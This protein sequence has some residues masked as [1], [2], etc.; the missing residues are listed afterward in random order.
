[1]K[2]LLSAIIIFA[3]IFSSC[4]KKPTPEEILKSKIES[5]FLETMDDPSSYEFVSFSIIDTFTVGEQINNILK[6]E[7]DNWEK[8][9][10]K[11]AECNQK[12]KE[13]SQYT[14][15]YFK[16]EIE[17]NRNRIEYINYGQNRIDSLNNLIATVNRDSIINIKTEFALRGNNKMGAKILS[18]YTIW[19]DGNSEIKKVSDKD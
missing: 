15:D 18:H 9:E 10:S 4:E 3:F 12:I 17:Q 19:F 14:S 2:K 1:M 8:R 5:R 7:M 16:T 6:Y 13:Y 11:I